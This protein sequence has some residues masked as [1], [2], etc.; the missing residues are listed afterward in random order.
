M[1][2]PLPIGIINWNLAKSQG[3]FALERGQRRIDENRAQ[4]EKWTDLKGRIVLMA[5]RVSIS[6]PVIRNLNDR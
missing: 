6:E 5:Y 4:G 3:S 2:W 1:H